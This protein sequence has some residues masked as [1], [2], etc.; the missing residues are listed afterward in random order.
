MVDDMTSRPAPHA[1][2]AERAD[3]LSAFLNC[4]EHRRRFVV[5]VR[6]NDVARKRVDEWFRTVFGVGSAGAYMG[7]E[8]VLAL[9]VL[10]HS[11]DQVMLERDDLQSSISQLRAALAARERERDDAVGDLAA[12]WKETGA[13][14]DQS[15]MQ[16]VANLIAERDD[17]KRC[18]SSWQG[19]RCRD[20]NGHAGIH[21]AEDESDWMDGDD[22][23]RSPVSSPAGR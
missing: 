3:S 21:V 15:P 8:T 11:R 9:C 19:R 22:P 5:E 18:R 7:T 2:W 16:G 17:L 4:V 10:L 12:I 20:E 1:T 23:P 14:D 6:D 13:D